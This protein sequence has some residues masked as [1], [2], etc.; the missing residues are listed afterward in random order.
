MKGFDTI[1]PAL[2]AAFSQL[3]RPLVRTLLH[4]NITYPILC[5]LLKGIYVEVAEH[6]L[7]I[8]GKQQSD[9][10]ITFLT[11][12]HRKDVRRLRQAPEE[13]IAN[14]TAA[15]L[16]AQ[17]VARWTGLPEFLDSDGHPKALPR[18]SQDAAEPSFEALVQTQ[19]KDIRARVVLDEW[20]RLGV[21]NVDDH[22]RVCLNSEAF[23]PDSGLD[24][25][26]YFMGRNLHD[27][28]AACSH[29]IT[30]AGPAMFE[31]S[32]YYDS[33]TDGDVAELESISKKIG[34]QALQLINRKAMALQQRS[35]GKPNATQRM[36]FGLYFFHALDD[37]DYEVGANEDA[38]SAQ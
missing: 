28:I 34:M 6:D 10:R 5:N 19:S 25:K 23:V 4:F 35:D 8:S 11:G 24:E 32:V 27:H 1:P 16:G 26:S 3:L 7:P 38:K 22:D 21:V 33:L 14:Q 17:L 29:N 12:I 31:R 18:L 37:N 15:T 13:T 9:S 36:N 20:L 30:D 2:M